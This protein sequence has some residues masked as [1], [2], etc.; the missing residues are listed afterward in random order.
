MKQMN[1]TFFPEFIHQ[2]ILFSLSSLFF[3]TL[4]FLLPFL[5]SYLNYLIIYIITSQ[6]FFDFS[7][8]EHICS[9]SE[10]TFWFMVH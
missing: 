3:S 9:E 10:I 7:R 1:L 6:T 2:K 4:T 8:E 5:L